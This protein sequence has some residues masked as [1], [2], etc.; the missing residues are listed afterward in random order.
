[1]VVV[2]GE[3]VAA[4][5]RRVTRTPSNF[6]LQCQALALQNVDF[7]FLDQA[8]GPMLFTLRFIHL[9]VSFTN[10]RTT[11]I[12]VSQIATRDYYQLLNLNLPLQLF[13]RT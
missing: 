3:F 1:M 11:P 10:G 6:D 7:R 2:S 9:D 8:S 12:D 13:R 5:L 4:H